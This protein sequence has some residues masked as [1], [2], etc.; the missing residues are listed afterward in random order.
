MKTYEQIINE[1]KEQKFVTNK[2][3]IIQ[4]F[5]NDPNNR[6]KIN[7]FN[8]PINFNLYPMPVES[9]LNIEIYSATENTF[10]LYK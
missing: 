7:E 10:E 5:L 3:D 8:E 9:V 2:I 1:I 6:L 4:S